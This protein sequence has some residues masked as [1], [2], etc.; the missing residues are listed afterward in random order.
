M[1]IRSPLYVETSIAESSYEVVSEIGVVL[2][3][4]TKSRRFDD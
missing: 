3:F 1:I 2:K 4:T